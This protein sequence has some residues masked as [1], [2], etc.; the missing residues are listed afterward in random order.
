MNLNPFNRKIGLALGGG[1]AKGIAHIGVLKRLKHSDISVD[2]ISGTSAGAIVASYFAFGKK[3][4][5]LNEL[6]NLLRA[7][8][9]LN[10]KMGKLGLMST[11]KLRDYLK[12]DL[13]DVNIE[14]AKIPLAICTTDVNTGETIH[15]TSGPLI[16][17]I[18]ASAA[19]P[20]LVQPVEI[21]GRLL[22]D[23]GIS[24]NVPI[25]IL[26]EMGAGITIGV[27]LNGVKNYPEVDSLFDVITNSMDIA[28]DLRTRDQLKR[29]DVV[30]PLDLSA[31][32]RLDN[33]D[34]FKDVIKAGEDGAKDKLFSLK[35]NR[36]F[37]LLYYVRNLII[38]AIPFKLRWPFSN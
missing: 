16:P 22:V 19:V 38:E 10:F 17:A 6:A 7:Q 21:D 34:S 36:A 26:T 15:F 13:G 1:A 28:I 33:K 31:F 35:Q 30:I 20:G 5:N 37:H 23:G 18:C 11:D 14:D 29:A 8:A 3:L 2:F 12:N 25:D 4:E 27:D 24:N 32:S 9:V